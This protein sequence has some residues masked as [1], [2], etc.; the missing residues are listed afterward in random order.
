MEK[1]VLKEFLKQKGLRFTRERESILDEILSHKGH[2]DLE[3]IYLGLRDKGSRVSRASVYRTVP[4]LLESG[5]LEEVQRTDKD[6]HAHYELTYGSSHHDHMIC[7]ECGKVMEF[8]SP[9]I[10]KLQDSLCRS[11]G[12]KGTS[13]TLE[14]RGVCRECRKKNPSR[15]HG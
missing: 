13:H 10:E 11:R 2:F 5:L 12:F 3:Q 4:L 8:R 15:K 9:S 14:I 1:D 7:T 6:K